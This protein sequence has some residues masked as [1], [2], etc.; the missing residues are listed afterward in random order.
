MCKICEGRGLVDTNINGVT[1]PTI[2]PCP[3][4]VEEVMK[5]MDDA[6]RRFRQFY[7]FG[8]E[9]KVI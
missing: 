3:P 9:D 8:K 5:A 1:F 7:I 6:M 2:C 4:T